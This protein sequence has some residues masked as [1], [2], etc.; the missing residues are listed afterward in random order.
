MSWI[1]AFSVAS[2]KLDHVIENPKYRTME[3]VLFF[4]GVALLFSVFFIFS[5]E[6]YLFAEMSLKNQAIYIF[7][8]LVVLPFVLRLLMGELLALVLAFIFSVVVLPLYITYVIY[9]KLTKRKSKV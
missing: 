2:I 8:I 9:Q 3:I 5:S 6:T 4:V 7:G 1:E